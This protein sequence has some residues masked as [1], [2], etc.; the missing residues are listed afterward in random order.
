MDFKYSF[1]FF[2]PRN[3]IVGYKGKKSSSD[4]S[5]HFHGVHSSKLATEFNEKGKNENGNSNKN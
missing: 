2:I 1:R 3:C 5:V 4:P